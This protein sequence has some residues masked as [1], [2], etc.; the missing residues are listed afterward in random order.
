MQRGLV[1]VFTGNGKGKTS[2]ALGVALRSCGHEMYVSMVQ[3]IKGATQSGEERAAER[4]KPQFELM[5]MGRGFVKHEAKAIPLSEHRKAA[6]E[7]FAVAAQRITS[8]FWDVVILDEINTAVS[9]GLLDISRVLELLARKPRKLH[10]ILTGRN[11]H[12]DLIAAAD[13]V[14]EMQDVKHPYESGTPAQEGIDF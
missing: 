13:L 14:T 3:F 5:V 2:A 8:G 1:I 6:E 11:A 10:V 12:P 9:L 4:L 7:A